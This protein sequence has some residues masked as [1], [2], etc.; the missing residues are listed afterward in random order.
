MF[1]V[2]PA[3]LSGDLPRLQEVLVESVVALG[4]QDH[5][6]VGWTQGPVKVVAIADRLLFIL[7]DAARLP[8]DFFE[9]HH[10]IV[11]RLFELSLLLELNNL[12]GS[13]AAERLVLFN[14][15]LL[16]DGEL[17]PGAAFGV[18][19]VEDAALALESLAV[20]AVSHLTVLLHFHAFG[21]DL[22]IDVEQA[23]VS[24]EH[25]LLG[26]FLVW[27][28]VNQDPLIFTFIATHSFL[29]APA[30]SNHI[31]VVVIIENCLI[32]FIAPEA[33]IS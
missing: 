25:H 12:V 14:C 1:Q 24:V 10:N 22:V 6:V 4:E 30:V 32:F 27:R 29:W 20:F 16:D 21:V 15:V 19:G 2:V 31:P 33:I 13:Q 8:E 9:V 3:I 26:F 28:R 17:V 11:L 18:L 5:E 23:H 7:I